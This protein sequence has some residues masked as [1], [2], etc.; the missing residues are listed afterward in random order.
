MT[1][2]DHAGH[3]E[4][5]RARFVENELRGFAA[6]E[7]LELLLYYAIPQRDVNPLAH[8]LLKHFGTLSAVL[9]A[10]PAELS[11]V[12]GV[13][14]HTACLISLVQ[15]LARMAERDRMGERPELSNLLQIKPFCVNLL[16][17]HDEEVLYLICL[18]ARARLIRAVPVLEGTID[19]I[20]VYP[21]KV[22][23]A[24]LQHN[25]HSV[26]LTHNH[27]SGACMPS[28]ADEA[29]NDLL[30]EALRAVDIRL[31]DHI[32]VANG[33]S[34]SL[35]QLR[36]RRLHKPLERNKRRAADIRDDGGMNP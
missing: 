10:T 17:R 31:L 32:I 20:A 5:M 13:G 25:A 18:D 29:T 1:G 26:L 28:E 6:H 21:R 4:R 8:S 19:E 36:S 3:R 14:E 34:A 22:V 23:S 24:A 27:P 11:Q 12:K 30:E 33:E 35:N 2:H 15:P 9:S 16:S 7:A